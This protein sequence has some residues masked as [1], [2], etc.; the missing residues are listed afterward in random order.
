MSFIAWNDRLTVGVEILDADHKQMI[1]LLNELHDSIQAG[2]GKQPVLCLFDKLVESV[3]NHFAREERLLERTQYAA[4]AA[5][6]H[7]HA[8]MIAWMSEARKQF[9]TSSLAT[10]PLEVMNFLKDWL[11]DHIEGSDFA[12]RAHL[13][14][15]GIY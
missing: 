2:E 13:N 1:R 14:A 5:Q 6:K 11:V 4:I 7:E 3:R 9:S 12:Y 15:M 8:N 10:P